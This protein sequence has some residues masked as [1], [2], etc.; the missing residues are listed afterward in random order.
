MTSL[1][2]ESRAARITRVDLD[3]RDGAS[4]AIKLGALAKLLEV[5]WCA[6]PANSLPCGS[7]GSGRRC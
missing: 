1:A 2:L 7:T 4:F 3:P 5:K 6:A